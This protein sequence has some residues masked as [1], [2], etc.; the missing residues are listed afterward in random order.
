MIIL[1][2]P[3]N[4]RPK[5]LVS[6]TQN[7][8]HHPLYDRNPILTAIGSKIRSTTTNPNAHANHIFHPRQ[9]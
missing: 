6:G 3:L 9:K 7:Q 5:K 1:I 8:N 2:V 4:I